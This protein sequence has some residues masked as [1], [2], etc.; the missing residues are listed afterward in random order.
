MDEVRNEVLP[1]VQEMALP[2]LVNSGALTFSQEKIEL[3]KRTIC[4]GGT[5]DELELFI[6]VCKRTGLDPFAR[7]IYAIKRWNSQERR[8]TL[9]FQTGIDGFRLTAQRTG[10]YQGQTDTLWC[11]LDGKWK[12]IWTES[13]PPFAAR[14]GVLRRGFKDPVFAVAR[15]DAYAQRN[16][17]G[18]LGPMWTKMPDVMIAKCAEALALRK[19]FPAELSGLYTGDEMGPAEREAA[20]EKARFEQKLQAEHARKLQAERNQR[21]SKELPKPQDPN[22]ITAEQAREFYK[23]AKEGRWPDDDLKS[24][25]H[26][27]TEQSTT[28]GIPVAKLK[29]LMD[30]VIANPYPEAAPSAAPVES[31]APAEEA[32]S[33]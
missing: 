26:Y 18:K 5:D 4:A 8:E 1:A 19:A 10:E 7:Q 15:F 24:L 13:A 6:M 30:F 31:V 2:R 17:D 27:H 20:D 3:L 22:L 23:K 29:I 14:V 11:G 9:A 12:E 32:P 21:R 28:A 16:K 33:K 25:I